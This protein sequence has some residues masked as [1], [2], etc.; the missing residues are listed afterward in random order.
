MWCNTRTTVYTHCTGLRLSLMSCGY[1]VEYTH[2]SVTVYTVHWTLSCG[3][4][5]TQQCLH[6]GLR[7]VV[8]YTSQILWV[9][10]TWVRCVKF[11]SQNFSRPDA[12]RESAACMHAGKIRR[13]VCSQTIKSANGI[14]T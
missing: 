12:R 14:V 9:L 1:V 7:H 5:H 8:E 3:G 4:I 13:S 10:S 11:C 2:N 6:T